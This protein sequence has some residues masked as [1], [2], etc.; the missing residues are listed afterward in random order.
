MHIRYPQRHKSNMAGSGTRL[1]FVRMRPSALRL[2][3]A[4]A[5][6]AAAGRLGAQTLDPRAY[7][8]NPT[9]ASFALASY[10]YQTGDVVFDP[11]VPITDVNAKLNAGA[12]AYVRT[13]G[14]FGRSANAGVVVPYVWGSLEGNVFEER[15]RITRSGFADLQM[16]FSTNILGSPALTP[17]EFARHPP[18][19]TLGFSLFVSAPSGEYDPTKLINISAHRWAFKP[20]LGVSHPMGKWVFE[21]YGGVWFFTENTNFF[22]GQTRSQAPIGTFQGHVSYTFLPRLWLSADATYY[23]GGRTTL[24]G[25]LNADLQTNSRVGLTAA[26]PIHGPHSIKLAWSRGAATRIGADFTT[27]QVTYQFLW[28]DR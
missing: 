28:F 7:A 10:A 22:G 16:R 15:R 12:V 3:A 26:L 25:R 13:F 5:V 21:L 14:L 1:D 9:G 27:Y 2:A 24:N 17:A 8:A 18:K 4:L 20:E 19:T 6:A 11:T 23:T